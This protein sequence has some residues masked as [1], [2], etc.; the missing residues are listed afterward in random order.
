MDKNPIYYKFY[1]TGLFNQV[2][3][4]ELAVGLQALTTRPIVIH[5]TDRHIFTPSNYFKNNKKIFITDILDWNN[6]NK[7]MFIDEKI[8]KFT[9]E[10]QVIENLQSY[11]YSCIPTDSDNEKDF[12][13]GRKRLTGDLSNYHLKTTLSQYSRFFYNRTQLLDFHL[14]SVRFKPEYYIMAHNIS[15]SLGKF[16]GMHLRITDHA[17]LMFNVTEEM[18]KN[19]L[20]Y[21]SNDLPLVLCTDNSNSD[22]LKNINQSTIILDDYILKYFLKD[23]VDLKMDNDVSLGLLCNLVMHNSINFIGT[24]GST[25]TAYIQRGRIQNNLKE[26]FLMIGESSYESQG[27]YSWNNIP[28]FHEGKNWWREWK[29]CYIDLEYFV[30]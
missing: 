28:L 24:P 30:I 1:P 20:E 11:Y 8:D 6:K 25:F 14:K 5:S 19:S 16:N 12:A 27:P 23:L 13:D 22:L 9:N 17:T 4:I 10:K 15:K 2:M 26:D 21:F 7:F 3:S 29:E 18:F